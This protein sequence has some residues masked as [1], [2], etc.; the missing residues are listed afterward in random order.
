MDVKEIQEVLDLRDVLST[1]TIGDHTDDS[2]LLAALLDW[3]HCDDGKIDVGADQAWQNTTE[4]KAKPK[5]KR[6]KATESSDSDTFE[7]T[8]DP[9]DEPDF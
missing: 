2:E 4:T 9:S 6:G 8:P 1:T 7:P 3:K 5:A